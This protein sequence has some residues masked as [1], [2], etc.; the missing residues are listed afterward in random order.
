MYVANTKDRASVNSGVR[1]MLM[2]HSVKLG[3]NWGG[4]NGYT[5]DIR[6]AVALEDAV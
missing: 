2:V 5:T 4:P 6:K 3:K 1:V